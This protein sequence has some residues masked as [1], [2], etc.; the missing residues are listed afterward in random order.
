MYSFCS[1]KIESVDHVLGSCLV[2]S[3]GGSC[4]EE[5]LEPSNLKLFLIGSILL[6][7]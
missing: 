3:C 5:S 7:F 2:M 6:V 4:M 1:L